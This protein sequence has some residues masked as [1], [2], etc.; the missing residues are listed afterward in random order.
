MKDLTACCEQ[1]RLKKISC[2]ELTSYYLQRIERFD[3]VLHAYITVCKDESL[4]QARAAD[5]RLICGDEPGPLYGAPIALKDLIE[6]KGVRTTSGS[7]FKEDYIANQ[8]ATLWTKLHEAGA[9]LLGKLNLHEFAYGTT[10][11]NPHYGAVSNPWDTSR[12]AGG[13]S[14]G[15][16]AAVAADMT[17]ASI[18]TDTGGSIR[19]PAACT[20]IFG[21][22]PT[23]GRVSLA[24]VAP[25]ANSLDH[26]GPMTRSVR[27]IALLMNVIAGYDDADPVSIRHTDED[28]GRFIG[29][30]LK[31]KKVAVLTGFFQQSVDEELLQR[32]LLAAQVLQEGGA[33][34]SFVDIAGM[35]QIPG[36]QDI[37]ISS[38]AFA[39]HQPWLDDSRFIYGD[40][41]RGRLEGGRRLTAVDYV[42]A[43]KQRL[44]LTRRLQQ[45]LQSAD[46]LLAPTLLFPPPPKGVADVDQTG[47][48]WPV[49]KSLTR[50]TNPFNMAGV[51]AISVP[52]G[53]T[54]A[55]LPIGVQ[56]IGPSFGE[57]ELLRYA[58]VLEQAFPVEIPPDYT[59]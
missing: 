14:G 11:E 15:S 54:E 16:A 48:V 45:V 59:Y 41:V 22:K 12:I 47:R 7:K 31:G 37:I 1:I 57:A 39:L 4:R 8:D 2:V 46:V 6:T 13:S 44:L 55:G 20:G 19:I 49:G 36:I 27:D 52:C 28:F 35:D 24:G 29:S 38:E 30:S 43:T 21:L 26:A 5:D 18:G 56:L 42:R 32:M 50:F 25:L 17:P 51:P 40:H 3:G 34:L 53:R 23:F 10:S 33:L 9:I 58:A